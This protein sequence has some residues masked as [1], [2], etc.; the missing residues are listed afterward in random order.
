MDEPRLLKTLLSRK[1][2]K[3]AAPVSFG[4]VVLIGVFSQLFWGG[5]LSNWPAQQGLVWQ[6]FTATLIHGDWGHYLSNGY[7]LFVLGFLVYG[8]FGFG[9]Y[10]LAAFLLS[11]VTNFITVMNYPENARLIGA[12]GMVY[13]LAGFWLIMFWFL[14]RQHVWHKRLLRILGVGL[15]ILFP[16]TFEPQVSYLAHAIGFGLGSLYAVGY[17]YFNQSKLRQYEVWQEPLV[18]PEELVT[19][20]EE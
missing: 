11:A 6:N 4:I 2:C 14:Q 1:P 20:S 3:S 19:N 7:M 8:Y 16:S 17:F 18:I 9:T 12:S 13:V 15:V 5:H 10:P